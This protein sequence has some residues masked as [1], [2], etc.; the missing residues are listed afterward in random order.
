MIEPCIIKKEQYQRYS[1]L[2]QQ[3]RGLE[4]LHMCVVQEVQELWEVQEVEKSW[5][6]YEVEEDCKVQEVQVSLKGLKVQV[7]KIW[8]V[9]EV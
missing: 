4:S 9:K 1:L 5:E 3:T 7:R 8:G 6:V 2:E